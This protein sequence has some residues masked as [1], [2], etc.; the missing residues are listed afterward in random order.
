[1]IVT[2]LKG[3][4]GNQMFQYAAG[5]C[6]AEKHKD[7]LFLE[8]SSL[9]RPLATPREY[10]LHIFN[11]RAEITNKE[12]IIRASDILFRVHQIK[13]G[14][15]KG[16]L[17]CPRG[18]NIV[19]DGYWQN[20]LYF[21]EIEHIIREEYTFKPIDHTAVDLL[22]QEQISSTAAVCIHVRRG[23][24]LLP[25]GS[26]FITA[27]TNYYKNAMEFIAKEVRD[28]YFYVFSD[29][30]AWCIENLPLDYPH[31][32]VRRD[33]LTTKYTEEDFRLMT[34]CQHFIIANSSFS[35]WAAWLGSSDDKI[36]VAPTK[37]FRDDPAA[38]KEI[39]PTAWV[40]L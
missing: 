15:H 39:T 19:L 38:S 5:K 13:R 6:L 4:L 7:Q 9:V 36:V 21:K 40:R 16:V 20:E 2:K 11:I 12:E 34:M 26:E 8:T 29:D 37:W 31:T 3:G 1:M 27:G 10:G 30:I 33:Q 32:F 28:P 22:L 18:G 23:D 14:F 25:E 17:E 24:Y 35:W